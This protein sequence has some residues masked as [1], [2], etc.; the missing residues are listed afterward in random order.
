MPRIG[1]PE[2]LPAPTPERG[3]QPW[4]QV[5]RALRIEHPLETLRNDAGCGERNEMA[6]HHHAGIFI[7]TGFAPHGMAI[8]NGD[9][10]TGPCERPSTAQTNDAAANDE[11][12]VVSGV[13]V[14]PSAGLPNAGGKG[15]VGMQD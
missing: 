6:G 14:G 2:E 8:K 3:I 9:R 5:K 10:A 7:R 15:V 1:V 4:P 12:I 11:D 13:G